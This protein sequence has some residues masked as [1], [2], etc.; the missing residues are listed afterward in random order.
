LNREVL[1]VCLARIYLDVGD[2]PDSGDL[3]LSDV[4]RIE[5]QDNGVLVT[6]LLGESKFIGAGVRSIDFVE[7]IVLLDTVEGSIRR[8]PIA[9]P[10]REPRSHRA[11][12]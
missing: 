3:V 12:E 5:F 9:H 2:K 10:T 6:E 4:T 11:S 1:T 7:G 8:H